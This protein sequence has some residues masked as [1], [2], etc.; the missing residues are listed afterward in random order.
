MQ[1]KTEEDLG[2]ECLSV[3]LEVTEAHS[4]SSI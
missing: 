4:V 2:N 3:A 1:D